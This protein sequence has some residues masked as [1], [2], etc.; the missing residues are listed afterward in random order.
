MIAA[1]AP[2]R[3]F[4]LPPRDSDS[5]VAPPNVKDGVEPTTAAGS[6]GVPIESS[7]IAS[8]AAFLEASEGFA[9]GASRAGAGALAAPLPKIENPAL[10]GLVS[11]SRSDGGV[12]IALAAAGTVAALEIGSAASIPSRSS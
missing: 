5:V 7:R 11:I 3:I 10:A 4:L 12:V 8:S 2:I 9:S 6:A 1:A